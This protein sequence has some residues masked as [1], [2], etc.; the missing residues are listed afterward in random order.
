M[1]ATRLFVGNLPYATTEQEL[2]ALFAGTGGAVK[3]VRIITDFD[4]RRSKGYGFVEMGTSEEAEKAIQDL[5]GKNIGGRALVVSEA[6]PRDGG[7]GPAV[8]QN[9]GGGGGGGSG[10]AP[11]R[12]RRRPRPAR[13][14]ANH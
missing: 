4:T 6:R 8:L 13:P 2:Q 10:G 1:A 11:P 7:G 9:R 12:R 5:N 14:L 3:S